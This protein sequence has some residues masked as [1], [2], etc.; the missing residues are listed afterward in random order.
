MKLLAVDTATRHQSVALMDG[1]VLLAE[2]TRANC[3]SHAGSLVPAIQDLLTALSC[4]FSAI[5]GLAVSAGPGSFTGLRVGLSTMVGFRTVAQ[6]PL[7][8]VPTLEAM[9]WNHRTSGHPV[10][11]MLV[12]RTHEV[13]WA[14]FQW[15]NGHAVRLLED[16]VGTIQDMMETLRQPTILFGEGWLRHQ[17]VIVD[18]MGEW[19][20]GGVPESMNPSAYH[21]GLAS[22]DAFQA[23]KFAGSHLSPHYVQRPDAEVQWDLKA[24]RASS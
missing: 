6:L 9:A 24:R 3:I 20:I 7:V 18:T 5:E 4:P 8:T 12:A 2:K 10:C 14:Q 13:Y 16:R 15:E 19:A 1:T 22:L 11:P 21:V 23:G 17:R